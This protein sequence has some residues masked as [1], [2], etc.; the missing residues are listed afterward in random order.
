MPTV[1][2]QFLNLRHRFWPKKN[3]APGLG[4][5]HELTAA[6][7]TVTSP[8]LYF[9]VSAMSPRWCSAS[10]PQSCPNAN[11]TASDINIVSGGR[12][13]ASSGTARCFSSHIAMPKRASSLVY[14]TVKSDRY[15]QPIGRLK[16]LTAPFI[17]PRVMDQPRS[18]GSGEL[19]TPPGSSSLWT[20]LNLRRATIDST[21][22]TSKKNAQNKMYDM[23]IPLRTTSS[24]LTRIN[25]LL[26][27]IQPLNTD[28][29]PPA[30]QNAK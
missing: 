3:R 21:I 1:Y 6:V 13:S 7:A 25:R 28:K 27:E 23:R 19:L 2:S 30:T 20:A 18:S 17:S 4:A 15:R 26:R 14:G 5:P 11:L 8:F 16:E 24:Q 9:A 10:Q 29:S 22:T 12:F